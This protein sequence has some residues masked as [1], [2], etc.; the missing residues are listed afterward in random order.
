MAFPAFTQPSLLRDGGDVPGP[1]VEVA[2]NTQ[3][4]DTDRAD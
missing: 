4:E 3:V 1:L 2:T